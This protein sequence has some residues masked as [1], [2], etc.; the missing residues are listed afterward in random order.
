MCERLLGVSYPSLLTGPVFIRPLVA[1]LRG[2]VEV[3]QRDDG[4]EKHYGAVSTEAVR[5]TR[6]LT[7]SGPGYSKGHTSEISSG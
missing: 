4:F 3:A 6:D 7:N 1:S 5:P 2:S